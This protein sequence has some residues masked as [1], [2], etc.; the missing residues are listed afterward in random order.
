MPRYYQLL[1]IPALLMLSSGCRQV[2]D[3][4]TK[5]RPASFYVKRYCFEVKREQAQKAILWF[6]QRYRFPPETLDQK[7]GLFTTKPIEMPRYGKNPRYGYVVGL[8]FLVTSGQGKIDLQGLDKREF[9][10]KQK[11]LPRPPVQEKYKSSSEYNQAYERYQKMLEARM[12][13]SEKVFRLM[14]KWQGC[15]LLKNKERSIIEVLTRITAFPIGAFGSLKTKGGKKVSSQLE[16]EY[17][18]LRVLGWKM[19][20]LAHM[21][22]LLQ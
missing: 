6:I 1:I 8:Q 21:R 13:R 19:K 11:P 12:R 20:Q 10:N 5:P 17:S 15:S 18:I 14:R 22:P 3:F 9:Q 4:Y 7:K 2:G 16:L